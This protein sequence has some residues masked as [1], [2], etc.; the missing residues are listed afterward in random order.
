MYNMPISKLLLTLIILYLI[1][2][3]LAVVL[4]FLGSKLTG[5]KWG[6][7]WKRTDPWHRKIRIALFIWRF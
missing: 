2:V 4:S 3:G 7:P 1:G 5:N 6:T